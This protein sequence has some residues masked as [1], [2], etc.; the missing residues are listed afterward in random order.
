MAALAQAADASKLWSSIAP[1]GEEHRTRRVAWTVEGLGRPLTKERGT[2]LSIGANE[3]Y[4]S[5][6][7]FNTQF[8]ALTTVACVLFALV[9]AATADP[10]PMAQRARADSPS[11]DANDAANSVHTVSRVP[12]LDLTA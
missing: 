10:A 3:P 4:F 2:S 11:V 9:G 6:M 8:R 5:P 1:L 7:L 12:P